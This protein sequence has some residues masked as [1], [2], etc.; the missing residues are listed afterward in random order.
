MGTEEKRTVNRI[1]VIDLDK[2]FKDIF[3]LEII[4][5]LRYDQVDILSAV[6]DDFV[7]L[8][9][10][11]EA[12]NNDDGIECI[13]PEALLASHIYSE[14]VIDAAEKVHSNMQDPAFRKKVNDAYTK[15]R[16]MA[17]VWEQKVRTKLAVD[18]KVTLSDAGRFL[19]DAVRETG[20]GDMQIK[21]SPRTLK[22]LEL[23]TTVLLFALLRGLSLDNEQPKRED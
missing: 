1:K 2:C 4:N 13:R 6:L 23:L 7:N 15:A 20:I 17:A 18:G 11:Y 19:A 9:K 14:T 3:A 21:L 22:W 8:V 16:P 12:V 10:H 5:G